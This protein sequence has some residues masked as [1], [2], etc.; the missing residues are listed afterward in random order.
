MLIVAMKI[1][2]SNITEPRDIKAFIES[3]QNRDL[4][5]SAQNHLAVASAFVPPFPELDAVR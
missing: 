4:I 2:G 5:K 1:Y 3:R